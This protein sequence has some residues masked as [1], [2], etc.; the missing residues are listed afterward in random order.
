MT[1][2]T[3]KL[4][5]RCN[6]KK[7][8]EK[9]VKDKKCIGQRRRYCYSCAY[10]TVKTY[11]NYYASK[12]FHRMKA[13]QEKYQIPINITR[14]DVIELFEIW[15]EFC[16]MCSSDIEGTPTLDHIVPMNR[17]VNDPFIEYG[18]HKA[19]CFV[20][21]KRCNDRKKDL[22]LLTFY[23]QNERFTETGLNALI[24][25]MSNRSGIS[26]E[27]IRGRLELDKQRYELESE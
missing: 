13:K 4:C 12:A 18:H 9:F 5:S 20:A 22:P 21:C 3:T 6:K 25:S 19:N 11:D 23:E 2:E 15:G 24:E 14:E 8:I 17:L 26:P 10:Q 27:L 7:P 16:V 1:V